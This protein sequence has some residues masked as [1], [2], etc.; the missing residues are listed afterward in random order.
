MKRLF[1][2]LIFFA[3]LFPSILN[4]QGQNNNWYFGRQ[5]ALNFNSGVP[6]SVPGSAISTVE[7]CA[8]VSDAAG[9]LLFYTDGIT[10]W[11]RNNQPLPG[12]SGTLL[13]D[14]TSSNSVIIVPRPGSTVQYYVITADQGGYITP[15]A[16]INYSLI[17]MTLNSGL[18][19]LVTLN[20]LLLA[21]P[22]TEKLA[23]CLHANCTDY[24]VITHSM[25]NNQF[26][27][28]QL[29]ASGFL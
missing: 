14:T 10:I 20:T 28:F 16:G 2:H 5:A 12:A 8:S 4:A 25:G 1:L 13:G 23:A 21:P 6:V 24:W 27:A 22:A 11:N 7:G 18:G 17:D 19:G 26:Q 29:T 9:N 15:N 3:S